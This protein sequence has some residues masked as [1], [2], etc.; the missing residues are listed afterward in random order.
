[1]ALNADE[2]KLV[3]AANSTWATLS[4]EAKA[5]FKKLLAADLGFMTAHPRI[6]TA[7]CAGVGALAVALFWIGIG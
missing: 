4:A 7:I 2:Q 1:M 5:E 3:D 6:Y